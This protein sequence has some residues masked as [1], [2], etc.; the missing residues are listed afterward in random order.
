M[1]DTHPE[2]AEKI[3][4]MMS[5]KTPEE[6]LLMGCSMHEMAKKIVTSSIL[7]EYPLATPAELRQKIFLRFYASD[8]SPAQKKKI[9]ERL[10][11]T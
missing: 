2:I 11:L 7:E 4:S 10:A 8:F 5:A 9:L 3:K 6:R 1:N